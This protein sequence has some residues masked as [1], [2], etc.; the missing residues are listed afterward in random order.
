MESIATGAG[1]SFSRK[2]QT[3]ITHF[4]F[5]LENRKPIRDKIF[6]VGYQPVSFRCRLGKW[7][8]DSNI[9]M[10]MKDFFLLES[11]AK[12]PSSRK[13]IHKNI[14]VTLQS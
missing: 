13:K 1:Q 14:T 4:R 3:S 9:R 7:I 2:R 8:G 11:V 5:L 12:V 10:S 6:S